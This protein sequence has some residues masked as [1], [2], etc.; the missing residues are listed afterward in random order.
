MSAVPDIEIPEILLPED[1]R[2]G[3]GPSR[4]RYEAIED[5]A[6][7]AEM[8]LGTSHRQP[9]IMNLITLIRSGLKEFFDAPE[10]YEVV[11][12]NGGSTVFWD[13]ATF[14]LIR[15]KSQHLSFG[16]FS[17]KFAAAVAAAP[18]LDEPTVLSAPAGQRCDPVAEAGVDV[19]AWPHNETSTGVMA[20]VRRVQ[21]AD[22]DALVVIDGTSGAAGLPVDLSQTDVYYF[23]PQKGFAGEGGLWIAMMSPR[24]L[25]RVAEIEASGRWIPPSL[26]LSLAIEYS[27]KNQTLNTPAIAT[28]FLLAHQVDWYVNTGNLAGAVRRTRKNAKT[29][30]GWAEKSAYATPFVTNPEDRSLVVGTIDFDASVDAAVV[31][32]VLRNNEI[33]DTE[34]YRKLGRNQLRIGMFPTTPSSDIKKLTGCIDYVVEELRR[35]RPKPIAD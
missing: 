20:P 8:Y 30:Y 31:A 25:D 23:A 18:F 13:I 19:Y 34:P 11:L 29:L 22:E 7:V 5:L 26:D 33:I 1:G 21:D 2:F 3:S 16:E 27:R 32:K 4:T 12:G 9:T 15:Q 35:Q 17:A 24:A 14:S 28:L 6:Q 10:G